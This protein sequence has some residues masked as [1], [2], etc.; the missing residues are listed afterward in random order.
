MLSIADTNY[1]INTD[2]ANQCSSFY[3]WFAMLPDYRPLVSDFPFDFLMQFVQLTRFPSYDRL[4]TSEYT[5]YPRE[6]KRGNRNT[7]WKCNLKVR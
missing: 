5:H 2:I 4:Y 3:Y 7:T 6:K 1:L